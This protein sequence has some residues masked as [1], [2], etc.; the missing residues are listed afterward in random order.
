MC[1]VSTLTISLSHSGDKGLRNEERWPKFSVCSCN[2]QNTN[3]QRS[4]YQVFLQPHLSIQ[5]QIKVCGK[6]LNTTLYQLNEVE[7]R[8][9]SGKQKKHAKMI[10]MIL[11]LNGTQRIIEAKTKNLHVE[12]WDTCGSCPLPRPCCPNQQVMSPI[13]VY[14]L[15]ML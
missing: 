15:G 8:R 14:W 4:G 10:M 3:W 2:H 5:V 11:H 1:I 7:G 13:K 9:N 12:I 6:P